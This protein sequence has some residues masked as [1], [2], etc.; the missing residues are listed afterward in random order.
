MAPQ[1]FK[2]EL[3]GLWDIN[4][5]HMSPLKPLKWGK[6]VRDRGTSPVSSFFRSYHPFTLWPSPADDRLTGFHFCAVHFWFWFS[7]CCKHLQSWVETT[8]LTYTC[9]AALY[10][11]CCEAYRTS[12]PQSPQALP[13]TYLQCALSSEYP[14]MADLTQACDPDSRGEYT[15]H[16]F[17]CYFLWVFLELTSSLH[18]KQLLL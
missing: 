11:W 4:T 18:R 8:R 9:P 17:L 6:P 15:R 1:Q 13:I 12:F 3:K 16:L 14:P 10:I 5:S 7:C 2:P